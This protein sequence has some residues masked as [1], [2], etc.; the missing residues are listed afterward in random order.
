MA[1]EE[2]GKHVENGKRP[3]KIAAEFPARPRS[4]AEVE[5]RGY[6]R[7]AH[8]A[9]P[10]AFRKLV[11]DVCTVERARFGFKVDG[12]ERSWVLESRLQLA[13]CVVTAAMLYSVYC[14]CE[15]LTCKEG[16]ARRP[17]L[18]EACWARA[19]RGGTQISRLSATRFSRLWARFRIRTEYWRQLGYL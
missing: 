12:A 18:G 16:V 8:R 11:A 1:A 19:R 13:E 5:R 14:G 7:G 15:A 6:R 9:P 3:Q 2:E 10:L 17:D 4:T